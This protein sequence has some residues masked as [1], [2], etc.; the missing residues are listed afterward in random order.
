MEILYRLYGAKNGD[1]AFGYNSA[2]SEPIWMKSGALWAHC[3]G[4]VL[5]DFGRDP[6]SSDSLI[7]SRFFVQVNNARFHRFPVGT[8]LHLNIAT[9]IGE[10]VKTLG[11]EFWKFYHKGSF[12]QKTQ[13]LRTEFQDF[14]TSGGH[15]SAIIT[16]R[17]KFTDKLTI[18]G[19]SSSI[20]PGRNFYGIT[21]NEGAK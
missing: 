4:L 21:P 9:S 16:D 8:I 7:G 6:R 19:M 11:T 10:V 20:I 17:Q 1:H 5:V 3:W 14:A 12:F 15:N 13:K 18:Y 2:K